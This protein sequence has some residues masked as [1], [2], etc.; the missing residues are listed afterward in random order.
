MGDKTETAY[1]S[2]SGSCIDALY[3]LHRFAGAD[4]IDR[5]KAA[6]RIIESEQARAKRE[7]RVRWDRIPVAAPPL[8]PDDF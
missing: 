3:S 1:R 4:A 6:I 7:D 5:L 2:A 8:S